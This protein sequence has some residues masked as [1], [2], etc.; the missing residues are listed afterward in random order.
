MKKSVIE[1]LKNKNGI[2]KIFKNGILKNIK[3]HEK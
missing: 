3:K 2:L 1:S